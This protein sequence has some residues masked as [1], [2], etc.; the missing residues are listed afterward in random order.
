MEIFNFYS[1]II[2]NLNK[3]I[4]SVEDGF[5]KIKGVKEKIKLVRKEVSD[6][7]EEE[8]KKEGYQLCN[9]YFEGDGRKTTFRDV[10]VKEDK[11]IMKDIQNVLDISDIVPFLSGFGKIDYSIYNSLNIQF[12]ENKTLAM[13]GSGK[14]LICKE[15]DTS[16]FKD[17]IGKNFYVKLSHFKKCKNLYLTSKGLLVDNKRILSYKEMCPRDLKYFE[18]YEFFK[19]TII[20]E[21][22]KCSIDKEV[23]AMKNI[24][25][26][27]NILCFTNTSVTNKDKSFMFEFKNNLP[28][29]EFLLEKKLFKTLMKTC[30][31][32]GYEI[33]Q[34]EDASKLIVKKDNVYHIFVTC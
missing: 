10:L 34:D 19:T 15:F 23:F 6:N 17:L 1:Q 31:S 7:L 26:L 22:C 16:P 29:G 32:G 11:V 5:L 18:K 3:P 12:N 2:D 24:V 20:K 33:Y 30:K 8:L 9:L 27:S 13:L 14:E 25:N 4:G 21:E 28:Y